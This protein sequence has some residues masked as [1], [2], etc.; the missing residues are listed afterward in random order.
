MERGWG[1]CWETGGNRGDNLSRWGKRTGTS[2]SV[3]HSGRAV[4]HRWAKSAG[5]V[6][7]GCVGAK[8]EKV[9]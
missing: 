2:W 5:E 4:L 1:E 9:Q 7:R 3:E 6:E 8:G